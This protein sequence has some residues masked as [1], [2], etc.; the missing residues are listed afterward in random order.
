MIIETVTATTQEPEDP[1]T[2]EQL[3]SLAETAKGRPVYIDF[4]DTR[5]VGR[6]VSA[7]VEGQKM[8]IK[9]DIE[10][11]FSGKFIVPG[12]VQPEYTSVAFGITS[13]PKDQRLTKI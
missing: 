8:I 3:H 7:W 10:N 6:I 4:D 1:F 13:N 11:D 5:E 9:A 12:F 2:L